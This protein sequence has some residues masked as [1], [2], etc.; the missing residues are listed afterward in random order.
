M[1]PRIRIP[2]RLTPVQRFGWACALCALPLTVHVAVVS[3]DRDLFAH[4]DC[5]TY[6]AYDETAM[7]EFVNG[8]M[9]ADQ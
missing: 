8:E 9:R 7:T 1:N 5:I 4:P 3:D 6:A 2:A